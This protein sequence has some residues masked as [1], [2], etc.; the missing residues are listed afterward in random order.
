MDHW[1]NLYGPNE[2]VQ[3][4]QVELGL[5]HDIVRKKPW[6]LL[7]EIFKPPFEK[8]PHSDTE[9]RL[10]PEVG[11]LHLQR[12][13]LD[14]SHKHRLCRRM[15]DFQVDAEGR[16]EVQFQRCGHRK[17]VK[18]KELY[19]P[20]YWLV[21]QGIQRD[22]TRVFTAPKQTFR[23]NIYEDFSSSQVQRNQE[24]QQ[25]TGVGMANL[26]EDF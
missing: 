16:V 21:D 11:P 4:G 23:S 26:M 25:S 20:N 12:L 1:T 17:I 13:Y 22:G 6:D 5:F 7:R 18:Y 10:N 15:N 3:P 8:V 19:L 14:S 9:F 24:E 2:G